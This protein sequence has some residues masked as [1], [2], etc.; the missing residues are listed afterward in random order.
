MITIL[1]GIDTF[2]EAACLLRSVRWLLIVTITTLLAVAGYS[3][4]RQKALSLQRD[5]AKGQAATYWAHLDIQN[6]SIRQA[7]KEAAAQQKQMVA[8]QEQAGRIRAEGE[9]W[10]KKAQ[11]TPLTGTCDEMLD[12]VIEAVRR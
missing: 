7:G 4:A 12:Q 6:A 2:L 5:A 3:M 9:A 11:Q 1:K 10:R 8:A